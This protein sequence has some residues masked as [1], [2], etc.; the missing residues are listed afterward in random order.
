MGPDGKWEL[1]VI[2]PAEGSRDRLGETILESNFSLG[3]AVLGARYRL[4]R[5]PSAPLTLTMGPQVILPSGNFARGTG[6]EKVGYAWDLAAAKDWR[7]PIFMYTSL[8]SAFFPSVRHPRSN[9]GESF[10]LHRLF[11]GTALALRPLE[12]S[13]A[14]LHHD[15]HLFLEFGLSLEQDLERSASPT[16][17]I[18]DVHNLVAPG[19]RYGLLNRNKDLY[20]I[21]VSFPIGLDRSTP[22]FGVIVQFQFEHVF[23]FRSE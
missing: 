4:L 23:R 8:N 10:H 21:G 5:E 7:G 20:E 22:S 2:T 17:K 14:G 13:R 3:D 11:W 6:F 16:R 15:L 18:S 12:K 9:P 1:D 19:I